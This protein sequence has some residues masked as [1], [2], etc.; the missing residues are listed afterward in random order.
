V[1]VLLAYLLIGTA[2]LGLARPFHVPALHNAPYASGITI[3]QPLQQPYM[4]FTPCDTCSA[5]LLHS[6]EL[7]SCISVASLASHVSSLVPVFLCSALHCLD[8]V[9]ILIAH[10][11]S[12]NKASLH[13]HSCVLPSLTERPTAQAHKAIPIRAFRLSRLVRLCQACM[14]LDMW[15]VRLGR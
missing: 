4:P 8:V 1:I 14:T 15:S 12:H 5:S 10:F 9:S 2:S 7:D 6:G 3:T 13:M 11:M